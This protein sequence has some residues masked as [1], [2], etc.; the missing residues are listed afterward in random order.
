MSIIAFLVGIVSASFLPEFPSLYWFLLTPVFIFIFFYFPK[1]KVICSLYFGFFWFVIFSYF[2]LSSSFSPELQGKDLLVTGVVSSLPESGSG[3]IRF[4]FDIDSLTSNN[5]KVENF[6][7]RIRLSWYGKKAK[8]LRA[9]ERWQLLVRLK[10]PHGLLN[11]GGFDY[12]KWLFERNI[13]A[14]GYVKN[15][16]E[17]IITQASTFSWLTVR[18]KIKNELVLAAG[19]SSYKGIYLALAL[20]DKSEISQYQWD[21][22]YKTGTSHLM[23][24]SG[25]HIGLI[26]GLFYWITLVTAKRVS[27]LSVYLPAYKLAAIVAILAAF[28]YAMLAGFA[29]PTQRALIMISIAMLLLLF[30]RR[31]HATIV[32]KYALLFVLLIDPLSVL[33]VGFW[34]SFLAVAA[35]LYGMQGRLFNNSL[36]WKFGRVQW[37]VSLGLIVPLV[38][39]FYSFSVVSPVVNIVAVPWVSLLVVPLVLIGTFFLPFPIVAEKLFELVDVFFSILWRF[40]DYFSSHSFALFD[41]APIPVWGLI[42]A[43]IGSVLILSPKRFPAKW[44]GGVLI[45]PV[46][47]VSGPQVADAE[48]KFSLLDVGQGLSAVVQ[49]KHHSLVYDTGDAYRSGFNMGDAVI[50]P[51]LKH[52]NIRTVDSLILSHGDKDHVGGFEALNKQIKIN[53]V[54]TSVY[55]E[56]PARK[57]RRCQTGQK[58]EWDG[59]SFEILNPNDNYRQSLSNVSYREKLSTENNMSCVLK[60]STGKHSILLTGDIEKEAENYLVEKHDIQL[61]SNLLVAP[62]H[63][64]KTSSTAMFIEKVDPDIVLFPQGYRNRF[65]HPSSKIVNRYKEKNIATYRTS[66]MGGMSFHITAKKI[67]PVVSHRKSSASLWLSMP[68]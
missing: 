13:R 35:I 50:L 8:Q 3:R 43:A 25:L 61:K 62:H 5:K 14:T 26:A 67:S 38:L 31:M 64:S 56:N 39:F 23:A 9:G 34:L 17:N 40:M 66:N 18:E 41:T 37:V 10:R 33:S 42:C 48:F 20:G 60:V 7:K 47:F 53:T 19:E 29:I 58:W 46:F 30:N 68:E 44:L 54:L 4:I 57:T 6:P 49:T 59:V 16:N 12:E 11:P 36:W 51:F 45:L 65:N 27:L 55:Q 21:V 52:E 63:G 22:F 28:F 2:I 1:Y 15:A 32:L 24:I